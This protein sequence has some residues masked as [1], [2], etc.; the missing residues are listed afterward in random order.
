VTNVSEERDFLR[1]LNE[2]LLANQKEFGAKLAAAQAA[3]GDK[4][5]QLADL[6]EQVAG[7]AGSEGAV[8]RAV[9]SG[10]QVF[11]ELE[12]QRTGPAGVGGAEMSAGDGPHCGGQNVMAE[13]VSPAR[14]TS[15]SDTRESHQRLQHAD[16]LAEGV[17]HWWGESRAESNLCLRLEKG[18]RVAVS[19]GR[20]RQLE[21]GQPALQTAH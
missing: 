9:M 6:Q 20:M 4:D 8:F 3:L 1:S 11:D 21:M 18:A 19:C 10:Q 15:P 17:G 7:L 12:R 5:K 2:T 14:R 16:S 13:F